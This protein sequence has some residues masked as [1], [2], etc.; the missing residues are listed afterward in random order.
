MPAFIVTF[1]L[2]S[3][4]YEDSQF[5]MNATLQ[6]TLEAEDL[7]AL[8]EELES[9]DVI[10]ELDDSS[11][12]NADCDESPDEINVEYVLVHDEEGNELY[13]DEDYEPV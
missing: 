10:D 4:Y 13:R 11:V 5:D 9:G 2:K 1:A 6:Q 8:F 3:F 7:D 12:L